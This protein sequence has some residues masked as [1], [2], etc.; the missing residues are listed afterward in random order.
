M[1]GIVQTGLI[2][3]AL[4]LVLANGFFVT[5]E[6]AIVKVRATRITELAQRGSR[7]ARVAA[8]VIGQMDEYL[9]ATQLGITL[10]SLGL[11]WIGK[12]AFAE[13]L[14][15]LLE[16]LGIESELVIQSVATAAAFALITVLHI[17]VGEVAP[18]SIAIQQPETS[19]LAVAT[20]MVVFYRLFYGPIWILNT[21]SNALL[22]LVGLR[23]ATEKELA[24]SEDEIRMILKTSQTGG[25]LTPEERD[26][27][28][29][30]IGVADRTARELLVPRHKMVSLE[31]S[32][33]VGEA[34]EVA[35]ESGHRRFPVYDRSP[36]RI[37]GFVDVHSLLAA[38]DRL[39]VP[40]RTLVREIYAVPETKSG[41]ELLVELQERRVQMAL[42]V[43]EYGGTAGL[44]TVEDVLEELVGEIRHERETGLPVRRLRDG[45]HLVEGSVPVRDLVSKYHLPLPESPE[46]E[47]I[48]GF[49]LARFQHIPRET[50][51][52]AHGRLILTV[53]RMD[54]LRIAWVKVTQSGPPAAPGAGTPGP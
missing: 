43:D 17:V 51:V 27:M 39:D 37:I 36:D 20:P 15:P 14:E 41:L 12:P 16:V 10:A 22:R 9:S 40:V 38:R 42:V 19:V 29:R 52:L 47:T 32:L 24:Y 50:A 45:S 18:K 21:M 13:L 46:Y 7:S 23:A 3:V 8:R 49:L 4:F 44:V 30:V 35:V 48:A 34:M 31:A 26:I 5:A 53:A 28:D 1:D 6:F 25:V 54:G 33:P 11:G 2:A